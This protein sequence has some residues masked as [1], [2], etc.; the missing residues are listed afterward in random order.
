[1]K[2]YRL[3]LEGKIVGFKRKSESGTVEYLALTDYTWRQKELS[4]DA[5]VWLGLPPVGIANLKRE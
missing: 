2:Y 1:M 3:S 4:H 5:K